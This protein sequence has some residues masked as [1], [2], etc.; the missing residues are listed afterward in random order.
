MRKLVCSLLLFSSF[1][2]ER[3]NET[4]VAPLVSGQETGKAPSIPSP[5]PLEQKEHAV[6]LNVRR[7]DY[8]ITKLRLKEAEEIL[9]DEVGADAARARARL[10]IYRADCEGAM[11]HLVS[12]A[13]QEARG[14]EELNRLAPRCTGATAGSR[15]IHDKEKGVWIRLQDEADRALLPLVLDVAVRARAALEKDLGEVLPRPLR[16]DLVR[17]LFSLSAVSGLPLEAAET[18]GTVAVARW[19]RV[20]MISPRAISRG[21]PWADTLAHEITHLLISRATADRAPL[22]LQEG[23]AK[24]EEHRWRQP[25]AFDDADDFSRRAHEAQLR[26]RS[27]GVDSI[28]PSIAMLPSAE[29]ASIAFAEVTSFMEY[30]IE[31]NGPHSLGFLLRDMEVAPDAASAMR[32]VSGYGVSDWQLIWRDDLTRRFQERLHSEPEEESF[33][34]GP[35][36][37]GRSLRLA[38]LLTLDGR[39]TEAAELSAPNLDRAPHSAAL[40]FMTARAAIVAERDD[41]DLLLGTLDDV[42]GADAGW[43]ALRARRLSAGKTSEEGEAL[44]A[45]ARGLDPLLAEVACDGE[46]WVGKDGTNTPHNAADPQARKRLNDLCKQA[47]TLPI[48][49]SR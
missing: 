33:E 21:F 47:K 9:A 23:I 38:E 45:Q 44:L 13:A 26:G 39:A 32:S 10:A 1:A 6:P 15:I 40:R 3:E 42:D 4:A 22:W 49:G 30:W 19:G 46:I 11:G 17:D 31:Q 28:G 8:A 36:E 35:R 20:T 7:A 29:D 43:L 25:Q 48:R 12:Q 27:I 5:P 37:L 16:I 34:M 24:R 2:C 18:T 14:A 41:V